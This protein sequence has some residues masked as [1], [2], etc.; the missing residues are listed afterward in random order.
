MKS[1]THTAESDRARDRLGGLIQESERLNA[2]D[3]SSLT[4]WM[5]DKL[6]FIAQHESG[7][8]KLWVTNAAGNTALVGAVR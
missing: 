8:P 5:Q 2:D 1:E 7:P 3:A 6:F 4:A